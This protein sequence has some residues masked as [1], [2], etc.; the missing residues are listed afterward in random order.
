MESVATV[1]I[2]KKTIKTQPSN[3]K[4]QKKQ[5]ND[6][7]LIFRSYFTQNQIGYG[8]KPINEFREKYNVDGVYQFDEIN[9]NQF[10]NELMKS[11]ITLTK[12]RLS[13]DIN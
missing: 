6:Y 4:R 10:E 13:E 8:I 1:E 2:V 12:L 7:P 11:Q 3:E 5:Q 9:K